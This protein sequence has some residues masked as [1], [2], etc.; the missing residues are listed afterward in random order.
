[1]KKIAFI[2]LA[3]VAMACVSCGGSKAKK[4]GYDYKPEVKGTFAA[5]Y[6]ID[7]VNLKFEEGHNDF[8]GSDYINVIATFNV[9]KN[10][11]DI[12]DEIGNLTPNCMNGWFSYDPRN[13][14]DGKYRWGCS[15]RILDSQYTEICSMNESDIN[16]LL[17]HFTNQGDAFSAE[18]KKDVSNFS[19]S[20]QYESLK[21][22]LDGETK[23]D[24]HVEV[25]IGGGVWSGSMQ[26]Y[27]K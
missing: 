1:M 24:L 11:K 17:E 22:F 14:Y 4:N 20:K 8:L 15:V 5:Y 6:D 18:W 13:L 21:K 12:K 16:P 3:V 25:L 19:E 27:Y 10:E 2:I 9:V 23:G 26:D 7:N